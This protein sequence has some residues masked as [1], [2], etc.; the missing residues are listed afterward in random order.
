[1]QGYRKASRRSPQYIRLEWGKNVFH[2]FAFNL[3]GL[4]PE[5][6]FGLTYSV[7]LASEAR[8]ES[9]FGKGKQPIPDNR[10]DNPCFR[11]PLL[12]AGSLSA[13]PR[14]PVKVNA[15]PCYAQRDTHDNF[16]LDKPDGP[17]SSAYRCWTRQS[18]FRRLAVLAADESATPMSII[19]S[20]NE[21]QCIH[22]LVF[23][24]LV[25]ANSAQVGCP[26][27]RSHSLL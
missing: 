23:H 15:F 4:I 13:S 6:C 8:R 11:Y 12:A 10:N 22:L 2:L 26:Q 14:L 5:V 7:I 3:L 9:Y 27:A 16:T 24:L 17:R 19:S 18:T 20:H 25:F 1:L 21:D